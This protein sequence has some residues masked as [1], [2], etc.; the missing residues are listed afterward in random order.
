MKFLKL[1]FCALV[2][3]IML[4]SCDLSQTNV[5]K[6]QQLFGAWELSKL[7]TNNGTES[8]APHITL[9]LEKSGQYIK[10]WHASGRYE[11]G[12]W[13]YDGNKMLTLSHGEVSN[14]YYVTIKSS[15][16]VLYMGDAINGTWTEETYLKPPTNKPQGGT[17]GAPAR[18]Q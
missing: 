14:N 9:T 1:L 7:K 2:V 3:L 8:S 15:T 18:K 11:N 10:Y 6:T 4:P 16:L 12:I 13:M 17:A 5:D